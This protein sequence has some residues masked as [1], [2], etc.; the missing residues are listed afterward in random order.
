MSSKSCNHHLMVHMI[1]QAVDAL[2]KRKTPPKRSVSQST[3][4]LMVQWGVW[5]KFY[6]KMGVSSVG[7]PYIMVSFLRPVSRSENGHQYGH[8]YIMWLNPSQGSM[9]CPNCREKL[10]DSK[11]VTQLSE[12]VQ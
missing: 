8:D 9:T 1:H 3:G 4:K 5:R 2:V 7:T 10:I 6:A 12:V 11:L